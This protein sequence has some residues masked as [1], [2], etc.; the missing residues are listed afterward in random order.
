MFG[1]FPSA[2]SKSEIREFVAGFFSSLNGLHHDLVR[3]DATGDLLYIHFEV[4]YE[5]HDGRKVTIP[6]LE[7]VKMNGDLIQDYVIYMDPSPLLA[8]QS[9]IED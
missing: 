1:S 8:L 5:V 7:T 4:T 2:R 3:I 9:T 6:A